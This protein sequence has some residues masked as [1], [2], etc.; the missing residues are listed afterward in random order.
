MRQALTSYTPR[1][2]AQL[3]IARANAIFEEYAS[4]GLS[5]SLRQVHY[6]FVSRQHYENTNAN[7]LLLGRTMKNARY[8]GFIDMDAFEDRSRN[9]R[10]VKNGPRT[11]YATR[12]GRS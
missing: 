4:H 12:L 1:A 5:L 2:D 8:G 9:A 6:Q 11:R 3:M 10:R 7:Y